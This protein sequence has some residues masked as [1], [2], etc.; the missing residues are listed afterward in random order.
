MLLALL[1]LRV[2]IDLLIDLRLKTLQVL[3]L[4]LY[5]FTVLCDSDPFIMESFPL[6]INRKLLGLCILRHLSLLV[7]LH[8]LKLNLTLRN[9][10]GKLKLSVTLP[11]LYIGKLVFVAP[12]LRLLNTHQLPHLGDLTLKPFRLLEILSFCSFHLHLL[13]NLELSL[14]LLDV[15][16]E[17]L[18][19]LL[20]ILLL[21]AQVNND[22]FRL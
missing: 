22:Q 2:L 21:D 4:L 13:F 20:Q 3:P 14:Q 7:T 1:I 11:P 8:L 10:I 16:H 5:F 18:L 9:Q 17:R 6:F 19:A 12:Q 15:F